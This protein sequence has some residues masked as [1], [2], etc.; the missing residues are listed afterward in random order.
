VCD[1]NLVGFHDL[2][3]E[4]FDD[5]LGNLHFG[6]GLFGLLVAAKYQN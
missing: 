1:K 4:V 5:F 6:A 3:G 2:V